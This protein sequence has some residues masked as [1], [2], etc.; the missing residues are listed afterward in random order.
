MVG[1]LK[2][3][4]GGQP[5]LTASVQNNANTMMVNPRVSIYILILNRKDV[6]LREGI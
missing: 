4:R 5:K 2:T 3:E 6:K 1:I